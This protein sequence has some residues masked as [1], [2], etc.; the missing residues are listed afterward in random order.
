MSTVISV[1]APPIS[2]VNN[3]VVISV[4]GQG[5]Q[6]IGIPAGGLTGQ[7]LIKA[8]DADYDTEWATINGNSIDVIAGQTISALKIVYTDPTDGKILYAD[9]DDVASVSS[10]LGITTQAGFLDN[11]INVRTAGELSDSSWSWNMGGNVTL[12]LGANGTIVQ[13]ALSGLVVIRIGYAISATKIMIRIGQPIL[14]TQE[15][16]NDR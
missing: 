14:T 8:T 3:E 13:G 15:N 6:G 5:A 10:L 7:G 4:G 9:K 12:Y 16:F 2:V 1:N 11:N